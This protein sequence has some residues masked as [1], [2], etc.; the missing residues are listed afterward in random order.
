MI[1]NK[2]IDKIVK[3]LIVKGFD[4]DDIFQLIKVKERFQ[5]FNDFIYFLLLLSQ[6][7]YDD[8]RVDMCTSISS[9]LNYLASTHNIIPS[10]ISQKQTGECFSNEEL[11]LFGVKGYGSKN[12]FYFDIDDN[13]YICLDNV[14]HFKYKDIYNIKLNHGFFENK[15]NAKII[16]KK[17]NNI[18]LFKKN[19]NNNY[20]LGEFKLLFNSWIY[21]DKFQYPSIVLAND[22]NLGDN[23][24]LEYD[25][26]TK[27]LQKESIQLLKDYLVSILN[28]NNIVESILFE[29]INIA[30]CHMILIDAFVQFCLLNEQFA[31]LKIFVNENPEVNFELSIINLVPYISLV[32]EYQLALLAN[33]FDVLFGCGIVSDYLN[34]IYVCCDSM[35]LEDNNIISLRFIKSFKN[36]FFD[37]PLNQKIFITNNEHSCVYVFKKNKNKYLFLGIYK[38]FKLTVGNDL[39]QNKTPIFKLRLINNDEYVEHLNY[40]SNL[41]VNNNFHNVFI[42]LSANNDLL[43][44][45]ISNLTKTEIVESSVELD[46]LNSILYKYNWITK[47]C[48]LLLD[49]PDELIKKI[50]LYKSFDSKN[51]NFI[52]NI[53]SKNF[54]YLAEN[55]ILK[56]YTIAYEMTKSNWTNKELINFSFID[57]YQTNKYKYETIVRVI[58]DKK[59]E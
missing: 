55:K 32:N 37:L 53:I 52:F 16:N 23:V 51:V 39:I 50:K 41:K 43:K 33:S 15:I 14:D 13:M 22:S 44:N 48:I 9:Y 20:Y 45:W 46:K 6:K 19:E 58:L 10:K 12:N 29:N 59:Y 1:K 26:I 11:Y 24:L 31:I 54:L 17:F 25:N 8:L 2:V 5:Q 3:K 42:D 56:P 36:H 18:Y 30:K 28:A 21:I 34:N 35:T 49:K 40:L 7:K 47:K 27:R 4:K 38:C 57:H